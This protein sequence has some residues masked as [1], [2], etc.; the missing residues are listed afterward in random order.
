LNYLDLLQQLLSCSGQDISTSK[1]SNPMSDELS[2]QN[3]SLFSKCEKIRKE[4]G[5]LA[6]KALFVDAKSF[7]QDSK[8]M[9]LHCDL[10]RKLYLGLRTYT[11]C[12]KGLGRQSLSILN[13]GI[14]RNLRP[15]C[16]NQAKKEGE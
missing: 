13:H 4:Y 3:S 10:G 12:L 7:P 8:E 1:K 6:K 5:P 11:R 9:D 16:A 2:S 14:R 15:R